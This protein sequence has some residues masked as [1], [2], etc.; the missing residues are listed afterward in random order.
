MLVSS[1]IYG[2]IISLVSVE[3]K[4]TEKIFTTHFNRVFSIL[5]IV[6]SF[7]DDLSTVPNLL[8]LSLLR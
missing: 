8:F 2:Y 3:L 7:R 6:K 4:P 1:S 5:I